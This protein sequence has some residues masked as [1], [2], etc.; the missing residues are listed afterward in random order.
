MFAM[1][2]A[3]SC[4]HR[5]ASTDGLPPNERF[6]FWR[7]TSL[8]HIEPYGPGVGKGEPFA[9]KIRQLTA[10]EGQFT[11]FHVAPVGVARTSE[12]CR[13]DGIDDIAVCIALD[14]AGA[15]WFGDPDRPT[16]LATGIARIR[17]ESRPCTVQWTGADNHMLVVNL[18]RATF[19]TRTL[20]RILAA[21]G[22]LVPMRGLAG[23][24]VAQ[25]RSLAEAAP[26]L[27]PAGR[28]A[29]L[30]AVLELTTAGLRLAF[31]SEPA[32]SEACEDATLIAAQ[33]LICRCFGLTDLS[34]ERIASRLGGSR[35]HLYRVFARNGLTIAG[36][37][38]EVRL[39]R[40]RVALAA[41]GPGDTVAD[42][43]FRCGFD[44]PVHFAHLFRRRFGMRPSDARAVS[45]AAARIRHP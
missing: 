23:M 39:Q 6:A 10:P 21:N 9:A 1:L 30:H 38:R 31:G 41:A 2:N 11:D 35:A 29:G 8:R 14:G 3:T 5:F 7:D 22:T 15:G 18:P 16:R 32:D 19:D 28:A 27:D 4:R 43:A 24:L 45:A 34:P 25:T 36:Y 13:G 42:I 12:L 33:A 20:V 17:D 40:C 44:N 26:D 37:L